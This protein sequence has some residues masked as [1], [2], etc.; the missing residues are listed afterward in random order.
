MIRFEPFC[1]RLVVI[2]GAALR[3]AIQTLLFN[4]HSLDQ[5]N[6]LFWQELNYDRVNQAIPTR[7]WSEKELE[8]FEGAPLLLA[9]HGDFKIIYLQMGGDLS[10]TAERTAINRLLQQFPYALF[11]FSDH[12]QQRW[13]FVNVKYERDPARRRVFRRITVAMGSDALRTA[14]ERLSMLDLETVSRD[15]FGIPPLAIQQRHDQAFDV[16]AV[17]A[18]FFREYDKLFKQVEGRLTVLDAEQRRLFTQKLFNRLLFIVFLERKGWLTFAGR[19]DYL[20]ALWEDYVRNGEAKGETNFYWNRLYTLFFLGLNNPLGFALPQDEFP[21]TAIGH[22][23]YLNGGLFEGDDDD[24]NRSIVIPDQLFE[25]AITGLF[26]RFN[27]TIAE[28]TPLDVEVAVDPEMLG[29]IFEE[30]VT[31]R[32]ESGSYYTPKPIVSFMCR[33]GLKGYLRT[34]RPAESSEAIACFVDQHDASQLR[35]AERVLDALRQITVCDPACGSGAYLLGMLQ[36]LLL[37]RGALFRQHQVDA[38]SAY[39]RKL[40]IIQRNI[41]GVDKDAFAVNIARLRL[42][43]SLIVDY[44]NATPDAELPTLPNLDYKLEVGNSLLGPDPSGTSPAEL[45]RLAVEQYFAAKEAYLSAHGEA[46]RNLQ[47]EVER[48]RADL[49]IWARRSVATGDAFD[50][51]VEFAEVFRDGGFDIVLANPPFV[52]QRLITQIKPQLRQIYNTFYTGTSDL[53]TYFYKRALEILR[54]SGMLV[55]ISS[56][57]WM[58]VDYGTRLRE[59]L[60]TQTRLETIV[61][62]GD[63]PV[64]KAVAYPVIITAQKDVPS[65]SQV[66][67]LRL[68]NLDRIDDLRNYIDEEA[69]V[70]EAEA[71]TSD[72]WSFANTASRQRIERILSTGHPLKNYI[73]DKVYRG[74]STGFNNA[75][76]INSA[77]RASLIAE[78][79]NSRHIIKPYLR[80]RDVK[81]WTI[82]GDN[83]LWLIF[84]RRGV[85]INAFPAIKEYLSTFRIELEPQPRDWPRGKDWSGR[86]PGSYKWYEIQDETAYFEKFEEIKIVS[87]KISLRP[88]FMLDTQGHYLGNTSYLLVPTVDPFLLLGILNSDVF[89]VYAKEV[90]PGKQNDWYEIQPKGLEDFPIP[91]VSPVEKDAI[92]ALVREC[93]AKYGVGCEREEAEIN[94]R[95]ALLYGLTPSEVE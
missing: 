5:L 1:F 71:I 3:D 26:Y 46:K 58:R 41:Y 17:T 60:A 91:D 88:T 8:P 87:T 93:V 43:L 52:E 95:V 11:V 20:R 40:E 59:L 31:G 2:K 44:D 27:F 51:A 21:A 24:E 38:R 72:R 10:R 53:Y 9:E 80:G 12:G 75:F 39:D 16:E 7:E 22:V 45:D 69:L 34:A 86:K 57:K 64:F 66:R 65:R 42:W 29:K 94:Q 15:L 50:W 70:V 85:D 47:A 25:Q 78:N 79:S 23:P 62:F 67:A 6:R 32:H 76:V 81:R 56:N 37:L 48:L 90:F 61:D 55:F 77:T 18:E 35:D 92:V 36:E 74:V 83:K 54:P 4:L 89:Q 14:T 73:K 63:L 84:T 13:H 28:S 82:S 49:R 68:M 30:L 33:E 19:T